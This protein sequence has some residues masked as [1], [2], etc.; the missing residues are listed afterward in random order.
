LVISHDPANRRSGTVIALVITSRE[1]RAGYP[2]SH[3]LHTGDLPKTS[4]VKMTQVRT[5][6]AERLR[7]RIG[8]V[9]DDELS[10]IVEGFIELIA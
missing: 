10:E 9:A 5:L 4:W 8:A 7:D 1:Q 2:F 6:S 3:K